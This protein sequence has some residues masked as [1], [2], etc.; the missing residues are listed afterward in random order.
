M[1]KNL[2]WRTLPYTNGFYQI[3]D[4][5][6]VRKISKFAN[7]YSIQSIC[8]PKYSVLEFERKQYIYSDTQFECPVIRYRSEFGLEQKA[9]STLMYEAFH[10][11][12]HLT[13]ESI[14]HLDGNEFK[15]N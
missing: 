11:I 12:Y 6:E 9:I 14:I 4:Q 1:Y 5:G 13:N 15:M 7:T 2:R 10:G 3:S 8:M